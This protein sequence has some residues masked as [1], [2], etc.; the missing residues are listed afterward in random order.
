VAV[1]ADATVSGRFDLVVLNHDG[2]GLRTVAQPP[3][4]FGVTFV[5]FSPSG[6]RLMYEVRD[7]INVSRLFLVPTAGGTPVDITPPRVNATDPLLGIINTTWSPDSRFLAIVAEGTTDR[8]NELYLVDAMATSP[9]PTTLISASTTGAVGTSGFWGVVSPVQWAGS[10]RLLFKYRTTTDPAFRLVSITT[11]GTSPSVVP[12]TPDGTAMLGFIGAFGVNPA[13][14]EALYSADNLLR[15][16]YELYRVPLTTSP[17]STI[18]T[19]GPP[20]GNGGECGGAG[21]PVRA[22]GVG[23]AAGLAVAPVVVR[24]QRR[25][26][27]LRVV[28]RRHA[29]RVHRRLAHRRAQRARAGPVARH[30]VDADAAGDAGDGRRR[31]RRGVDAL[32]SAPG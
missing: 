1:A 10:T 13:G 30:A 20:R 7:A 28:A 31:A 32:R 19:G 18:V 16:A 5:R 15:D 9:A 26:R 11:S 25:H 3:A 2:T 8:L 23:L 29:A 6:T 22:V 27:R 24:S 12:G 21:H 14:T 4:G 17:T